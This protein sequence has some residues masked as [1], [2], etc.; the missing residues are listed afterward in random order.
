MALLR[1]Y[2]QWYIEQRFKNGQQWRDTGHLFIRSNG[3][4]I[5]PDGISAW[6]CKFS[7]KHNL[8]QLTLMPSGI[9]WILDL[10]IT[11]RTL[12][13]YLNASDMP[14]PQR[15]LIF[16]LL[17]LRRQM[18]FQASASRI[19]CLEGADKKQGRFSIS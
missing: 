14:A 9:R 5:L 2:K 12:Y 8:P 13:P 3:E 18:R 17:S 1:D 4:P 11:V 15:R 16:A 6:M 10:L 19:H 7:K